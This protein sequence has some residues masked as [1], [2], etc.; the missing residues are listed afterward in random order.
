MRKL[1]TILIKQP[2]TLNQLAKERKC[3]KNQVR[4][5]LNTLI[6]RGVNVSR[7]RSNGS[8]VYYIPLKTEPVT[9]PK[10]QTDL[11]GIVADTHFGSKYNEP[12]CLNDFYDRMADSGVKNVFHLGDLL[13]GVGVYPG[14]I[15]HLRPNCISLE[16][17][18]EEAV[19]KYP[20]K[21]DITTYI[22]SGNHDLKHYQRQGVDPV[23]QFS[24]QRKDFKY[25]GQSYG[26][27]RLKQNVLLEMSHP[28]GGAPYTKGYKFRT[29]LRERPINTYP[30]IL[31][32]GH[33]HCSLFEDVQGT[34]SYMGGCFMGDTDFTRRKGLHPSI[35]GWKVELE[36]SGGKIKAAKN[37][38]IRY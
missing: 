38:F 20:Q 10:I 9:P 4:K 27:A 1:N 3:S 29:Y 26:R 5:D 37:E 7:K 36:I 35:G 6:E 28:T 23:K 32:M 21:K 22:I 11:F 34:L 24:I 16:G 14:Q 2:T 15:N 17:Q 8:T 33:L 25:L 13:E 12:E 19:K 31:A 30:D 18:I